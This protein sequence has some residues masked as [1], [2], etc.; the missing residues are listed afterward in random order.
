[1]PSPFNVQI[2]RGCQPSEYAIVFGV[3]RDP[4]DTVLVRSGGRL[5]PLR[6]AR[7]PSGLHVTGV[8]AFIA[9]PGPPTELIVRTSLGRT[10]VTRHFDREAREAKETCEGEVEGP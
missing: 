1:H 2:E 10:V 4:T 6:H 9:L 8:L 7:I 3:L 5:L